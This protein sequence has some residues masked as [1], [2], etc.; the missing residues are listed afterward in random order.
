MKKTRANNKDYIHVKDNIYSLEP[1]YRKVRDEKYLKKEYKGE[2][3][4]V[5]YEQLIDYCNKLNEITKMLKRTNSE[6]E[7][8]IVILTPVAV[9]GAI[10]FLDEILSLF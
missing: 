6:Y 8:I 9:Y 4:D 2:Y 10:R 3:V 5:T 1:R 7:R